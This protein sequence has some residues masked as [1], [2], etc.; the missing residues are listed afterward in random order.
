MKK[1]RLLFVMFLFAF[2]MLF[3]SCAAQSDEY[4]L[5]SDIIIDKLDDNSSFRVVSQ[6]T[7]ASVGGMFN[8]P[9][10]VNTIVGKTVFR[11]DSLNT[12]NYNVNEALFVESG[13]YLARKLKINESSFAE[14]YGDVICAKHYKDFNVYITIKYKES[15]IF[16]QAGSTAFVFK[17]TKNS[18]EKIEFKPE[19]GYLSRGTENFYR[20]GDKLAIANAHYIVDLNE[21]TIT[22][23]DV[24]APWGDAV[25]IASR[26]R[27]YLA[28]SKGLEDVAETVKDDPILTAKEL[29]G[30]LWFAV[31]KE[32]ASYSELYCL[33]FDA[34]TG[35]A[36]Y[37]AVVT[38]PDVG[39][40]PGQSR[41]VGSFV[42]AEPVL[43]NGNGY[44][45]IV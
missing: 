15:S 7:A 22:K 21:M 5:K 10:H 25:E 2:C 13:K 27:A 14:T 17:E 12:E 11:V 43:A 29:E 37:A 34:A 32:Y 39:D 44:Y 1:K 45:D 23:G 8:V 18:F 6:N 20:V 28:A 16:P 36:L 3:S 40:D 19:N 9:W 4:A 31:K 30:K 35:E 33:I 42:L 38:T 41:F 26:C 24:E